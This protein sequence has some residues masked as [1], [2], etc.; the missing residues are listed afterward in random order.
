M[1]DPT[2]P[3]ASGPLPP[4]RALHLRP[5]GAVCADPVCNG[6]RRTGGR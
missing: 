2:L 5:G 3:T 4:E 1:I 6:L